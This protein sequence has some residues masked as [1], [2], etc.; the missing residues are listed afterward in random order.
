MKLLVGT[1]NPDAYLRLMDV[2]P[3]LFQVHTAASREQLLFRMEE[4]FDHIAVDLQLFADGYPWDVIREL[5]VHRCGAELTV[6]PDGRVYDSLFLEVLTRL[7]AEA[8]ISVLSLALSAEEAAAQFYDRLGLP[9]PSALAR[10][11]GKVIA[12]WSA[13][14]GDGASTVAVNT[15]LTLAA[16]SELSIGLLDLNLKN[17]TLSANLNLKAATATNVKLR[18]RLQTQSLTADELLAGCITNSKLR[19]LFILP[20]SP[21]RDS[22]ADFTPEMIDRLLTV[23]RKAFD[24]T[25]LDLNGYPD[26]AATVCGVRGADVRWLVTRPRYDSYRISWSEW[27][28]CYWKYCGLKT[29]DIRFV[30][31]QSLG[32]GEAA[33]ASAHLN[34]EMAAELPMLPLE[35]G[36][37]AVDEGVPFY[38]QPGA[39][40][41]NEA[42]S[43]LAAEAAGAA[44]IEMESKPVRRKHLWQRFGRRIA[45][46]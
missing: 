3:G 31:N 10:L 36:A 26:N 33:A 34:M 11:D 24:L 27:Y 12:V 4:K 1:R 35:L 25:L 46:D 37:K 22:A 29:S 44:G 19:R 7:A 42:V 13:A 8:D 45:W 28:A 38:N 40:S 5:S 6:I 41:F 17:P 20:G 9:E 39:E 21:R 2:K 18:P 23:S 14:S 16:N 15:A 32:K 30:M 43:R